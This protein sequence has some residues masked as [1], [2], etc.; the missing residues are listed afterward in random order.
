MYGTPNSGKKPRD[1]LYITV[2]HGNAIATMLAERIA[3]LRERNANKSKVNPL[4]SVF[5]DLEDLEL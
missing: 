1:Q 2:N 5:A 4:A 3:F